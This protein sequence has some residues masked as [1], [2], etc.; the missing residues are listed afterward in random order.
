MQFEGLQQL[1]KSLS[2]KTDIGH[3]AALRKSK[4][5]ERK[6]IGFGQK[7]VGRRHASAAPFS[8]CWRGSCPDVA[9]MTIVNSIGVA[10]AGKGKVPVGVMSGCCP[11]CILPWRDFYRGTM[12]WT[13]I[14][15]LFDNP[16]LR[17]LLYIVKSILN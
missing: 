5:R 14:S 8:S 13:L 2:K 16:L 1:Q 12:T 15:I 6:E 11:I 3:L 4:K 9:Q 17:V 7:Y 10:P